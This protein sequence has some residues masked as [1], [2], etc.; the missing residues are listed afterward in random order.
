[1]SHSPNVFKRLA[2]RLDQMV[3][4]VENHEAMAD[5]AIRNVRAHLARA[6]RAL[7]RAVADGAHV[8]IELAAQ[9]GLVEAARRKARAEPDDTLAVEWLRRSRRAARAAAELREQAKTLGSSTAA[10]ECEVNRIKDRLASLERTRNLLRARE[11]RAEALQALMGER[12]ARDDGLLATIQRWET[13]VQTSETAGRTTLELAEI[14]ATIFDDESDLV[15]ELAELRRNR[16]D[17]SK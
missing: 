3:S 2:S 10:L 7:A 13:H 17:A 11:R 15:L 1:M 6:E 4:Q 9:D 16:H 5:S 14:D 12:G 8:A